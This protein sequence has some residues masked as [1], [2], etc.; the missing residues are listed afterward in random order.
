MSYDNNVTRPAQYS[1]M[2]EI[3]FVEDEW[4]DGL[5]FTRNSSVVKA[6]N[7]CLQLGELISRSAAL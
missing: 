7:L 3:K 2:N 4:F 5:F 1:E 6:A